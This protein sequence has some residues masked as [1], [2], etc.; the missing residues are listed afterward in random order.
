VPDP[1]QVLIEIL[2]RSRAL[3]FLGPGPV[4]PHL[5]HAHRFAQAWTGPPPATALDLGSGGGLPGLV[6]VGAWPSTAWSLLDANRRRTDFLADAV[7]RLGVSE[8]V[9]VL[10]GR[11]EE[12]G[13]RDDLRHRFDVVTARSF[14]KPAVTAECGAGFLAVGATLLVSEPPMDELDQA[15]PAPVPATPP[16]P[17]QP[18]RDAQGSDASSRWDPV[19]LAELGLRS[20]GRR[21]G[22]RVLVAASLCPERYPR[23]VGVPAKRPLFG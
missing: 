7:L 13:H 20:V 21:A 4:E 16:G 18:R 14:A 6:L 19:G 11:A 9:Q 2:E 3:G 17:G 22:C 10:H 23:R 12:L 15:G 5:E 8:R 1:D